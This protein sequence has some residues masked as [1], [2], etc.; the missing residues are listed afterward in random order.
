MGLNASSRALS[1]RGRASLENT[2]WP[3][4]LEGFHCGMEQS[5]SSP[6]SLPGGRRFKSYSRNDKGGC[7][8]ATPLFYC[9]KVTFVSPI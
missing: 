4:A 8:G 9:S 1:G 6:E 3:L 7:P 5:G 2:G